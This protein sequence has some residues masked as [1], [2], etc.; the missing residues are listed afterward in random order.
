MHKTADGSVMP[1]DL[2][3]RTNN[4]PDTQAIRTG[5]D[6]RS[7]PE[8]A[9]DSGFQ[10]KPEGIALPK[11]GGAIR[12]IGEKFG[13]NPVT[14]TGSMSVPIAT[15]PGRSGFSPQLSLN[16][17]SGAGNGPF[18]F[19]W[20]LGLPQITRKTDKGLPQYHDAQES[21]VYILSGTEDLVPVTID[22][23][24]TWV[25]ER[26][27]D[28]A[29]GSDTYMVQRYRPR[30]EGLFARIERW[31]RQGDGDVHWRSI[32]RDNVLTLY[33]TDANSR[34]ADAADPLRV[35]TW[36][37]SETRDDKG[38]A[39]V[40]DYKAEDGTGVD[41][42]RA[43]ERNR[44][45][46]DDPRR[47]TNRHL[48]RIRYGNR[49]TL[50]D[51]AGQRPARL[52]A[53]ALQGAGWMFEAVFDYGEHVAEAPTPNEAGPW[54]SRVDPFSS[55]RAGFE[56]RTARLCRRVLMFHH[57]D[58]EPGVGTDCLVR[59]TDFGYS[60]DQD[61][62]N[63][64]NPAYT[65]LLSVTQ[66]SYKRDAGAYRKRSLPPVEFAYTQPSVQDSVHELDE[67]SLANLPI[68]LDGAAYQWIDLHGEGIPGILTEQGGGWFY[69]RNVSPISD[70]QVEFA[71]V[72]RVALTPNAGL[73][74]GQAQFM[75]LAGDGQPDL[76]L[77][78]GPVPGLYEHGAEEG[79]E[80]FR[81]FT[82]YLN[83][84]TRDPNLKLVDLDGDGHADVL[85]SENDAFVWHAS[86]AE[87]GFGPARRVQHALDDEQ[88]PR[89]VFADGTESIYLADL[90]GDG[91]T[92]LVRIRNGGV[93][94]WP[95]LG[96]GRF[97]AKVTMD[98]SPR[99]DHP[100]QFD[101]SRIR[102]ADV[103]GSGTTDIIYLHRD[104]VRLYFNQSGNSWSAAQQ[105]NVFPR[106]DDFAS[107]V[108]I[109]LFGNGTACLVWSSPLPGDARRSMRYV[110]LMGG[111]KP[112]LLVKS[113]NNLGAETIVT[114]APSTKF[115]LA[116]KA[117]GRPWITKLPF[118][119]HCVENVTVADKW[120]Q[121][122]FSTSYSYHHGFF[123][124]VER[125]FRGFGR[126]E[127][128]DVESYGEFSQGNS[129]SPYITDDKTLYQPPVKTI[130]W[131]HTGAAS[132]RERVLSQFAHEYFPGGFESAQSGGLAVL[133]DFQE[134][135]LPEPDLRVED[136]SAD[137]W[138]ETLRACRG[139]TLRQETYELDVDAL[140][141]GEHQPVKLF[142]TAY[143]NCHIRR[144][145]AKAAN[146][147]AVF[148][149]AESEAITYHYELD[150][151]ADALRPD[152][153]IEHTLHLQ[154]DEYANILQ[155]VT[156]VYPRLGQ[157]EDEA[158][159]PETVALIR[160][161]QR[162]R[163]VA[164]AETRYTNDVVEPDTYRLR[165]P[166]EALTYELTGISPEDA[167]DQ[168]T[169]N[170]RDNRYFTLD[171]LRG[172]RLSEVHQT[173]GVAVPEIAYHELANGSTPQKRLVEH[174]RTLF[175]KDDGALVDAP[176]PLGQL[177]R[178]GLPF[179]RYT[180]ALTRDLLDAVFADKLTPDALN[181][182]GDASVSGY[183]S[184]A[185]LAMRFAG[186]G[187][188]GQ[189][190]VRSGIAG[191]APDAAQHFYLPERFTDPFGNVTT[192]EYDP[193]DLF[194]A[195][196][197]DAL[198][199][200]TRVERFDFRVLSPSEIR[201][202]N[203]NLSEVFFD[204]LGLPSAMAVQGKGAEGDTLA[205][206]TDV[207]A[208]PDTSD[209]ETFFGQSDLDDTQA[210]AWLA[211][212][213]A[214]HI[215]YFG[216]TLNADGTIAWGAHPAC[217]CGI[218][219]ETHVS[220][221]APGEQSAL[222]TSFEYSDGM[223]SVLVKKTQAEPEA[224][225]QPLR[226]IAN[227]KTI[228]NNK[229][230]AVKQYEP[231]FS[232]LGHR[233]EEPLEVGVTA[234]TYYDAVGR[235]VRSE[236]PDGTFSRV[237]FSPWLTRSFDANDTVRESTWYSDRNPPDPA[238]PLPRDI[239]GRLLVTQDQRAAW[240]AAQHAGTPSLTLV[241]SL[242]RA[243]IVVAHN[244]VKDAAGSHVFGAETW[245]DDYQV[246]FTK[247]DAEGKP[248]W[249]RDARRNLVM[250]YITPPVP[251]DQSDDPVS[252]FAPCYDIAGNL[253]FQH[254][255]DAGERW[256]LNDAAGGLLLAW[257]GRG[258][259]FRTEYDP[260]RR[261]IA[262]FGSGIDPQDPGREIQF[263]HVIYGDTPNNGLSDAERQALNVRGKRLRHRDTAGIVVSV[264]LNPDTGEDEAFDFKGNLLRHT[265]QLIQNYTSTSDWSQP[266]ALEPELFTSS[267]RFDALNRPIQ[268]VVPH[269]DRPGTRLTVIRPG[270]NE[271]GLLG[272]VDVWLEQDTEPA[273][274]LGVQ[275]ATQHVVTDVDYDAKGQRSRIRYGNGVGTTYER[276]PLT[277]RLIHLLT[278]R[279][280]GFAD[281]WP[282][283]PD[284]PR[285]GIQ[286]LTYFYDPVGNITHIRDEAQHTIFFSG[287]R[288]EPSA[289][290]EYDAIYRLI[291][292]SGREHVGQHASP[293]VTDDDSP[294]M[295]QPLPT[296][297]AALRNYTER[298]DYDAVGNILRMIH[299]AGANGSWTR[300]YD[301][302]ATSN[303]LLATSLPGDAIDHFS[304]RY[305]YD[306]HGSMTRM[307][308][309]PLM[310]WDF[311]DRLQATAKQV[312]TTGSPET[313]W[314][315]YDGSGQ[316]VR[317]VT[318]RPA[319][320]GQTPT[321][322][323]E[324][325]YLDTFE[326]YRE[327]E[328]DGVTVAL[329][330]ETLNVMDDQQRVALVETK[331][332]DTTA[333]FTSSAPL[334]RYQFSNHLGSASLELNGE[335]QIISYEEYHPYG[336][337]SYQGGRSAAEVGL[338]RYRYIG[339]ERDEESGLG[340]HAARYYASWLGRW[341]SCDP[342][343]LR[344]GANVY[345]YV[346]NS[347][348]RLIDPEGTE[349][350]NASHEVVKQLVD[351]V[352][353][354][355]NRMLDV[356]E[357]SL[358]KPNVHWRDP[359]KIG[360]LAGDLIREDLEKILGKGNFEVT[361]RG[362]IID[363][364]LKEVP[365]DI[366]L[367][368]TEASKRI[369]QSIGLERNARENSR[370]LFYVMGDIPAE[371]DQEGR[372]TKPGKITPPDPHDFT[373][374]PFTKQQLSRLETMKSG[375]RAKISALAGKGAPRRGADDGTA[376]SRLGNMVKSAVVSTATT[377][378]ISL[379]TKAQLPSVAEVA[380][381]LHPAVSLA[382]ARNHDETVMPIIL[383][384]V[385]WKVV[386][387]AGVGYLMIK[388]GTY[389][390]EVIERI[391][392]KYPDDPYGRKA[393]AMI[394]MTVGYGTAADRQ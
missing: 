278:D 142:S 375:I 321:R 104:G 253:L 314:Y 192:V 388:G 164:Y 327:Y 66:S 107:I 203:A 41:L 292:A 177:G 324:R 6:P 389:R 35:F 286:N 329:E 360:K 277:F 374:K 44:G 24:G 197:T 310:R 320:P 263:D 25:R 220:Q 67:E 323:K 99:F 262:S 230:K 63:A 226:W 93:C 239:T 315:V 212:A 173:E 191:F 127:Q 46:R 325:V 26:L 29:I 57:F 243:V 45:E 311:H 91:L 2:Q 51:S 357:D 125:E 88:G 363:I 294:R 289:D 185:T 238:L 371:V 386:V 301:Y 224:P 236:M 19:G 13:A 110:D 86:L 229:D 340:Y 165:A 379:V 391:R 290:Y 158:L 133:G 345:A 285:G 117:A 336:S 373:T 291:T 259:A 393:D 338:K 237:E 59:S 308:H 274:L 322:M 251:D 105:L 387:G 196:T 261:S 287:Q 135:V 390:G 302:D 205:G 73:T 20:A 111:Q 163:H 317:K 331:T 79:W 380:E 241:D 31:T 227:G 350:K 257:D 376:P 149:V 332:L 304:G 358:K 162:E 207:L 249:I 138:R 8:S 296:D 307:P 218:A 101:H 62:A 160:S 54:R 188:D 195:S 299:Q 343:G 64:R 55:Y 213:S 372:V 124:G 351:E 367:K 152:P 276:D 155:S 147:H 52:S 28:R 134:N 211:D 348:L 246:T 353:T 154:H 242:G 247:L 264:G 352:K 365:L 392:A 217:A 84:D 341:T 394:R 186:G 38:N 159:P 252:G 369:K 234:L 14:G 89:L 83:R 139:M 47:K 228:L 95:N 326:V 245:R 122:R 72:E 15:S 169:P 182:L 123:D 106:V 349:S 109:D 342:A 12:G 82:A 68:G 275:S 136:S 120:R 366:E 132:E 385:G 94:F 151:R 174:E 23:N 303:R 81:P 283:P 334:I 85:V 176:L 273:G 223:G 148:L 254:S 225:S 34:I 102:L 200:T 56:V 179:E 222:Q 22:Q 131:Y 121:T 362:A 167:D 244:R 30:I 181:R 115:Y 171:E 219:R 114:Y 381:G 206:L 194:M 216:E 316:R 300:R 269:S 183:L 7:N 288:V 69:K 5:S 39:V 306:P 297:A 11:G 103:D 255:M 58:G 210:R 161:V 184:G 43:H 48:K 150:L 49:N 295:R 271:G 309:L 37:I 189:Y 9:G 208:N 87:Q 172:L 204:V 383:M 98:E 170:A 90:D 268:L 118:P 75:D 76:V 364:S 60:H 313:T 77:L 232:P 202:I 21:D 156:V 100:D 92:D 370:L 65:F 312:V 339:M 359:M 298:Y 16:Y 281:D 157:F 384:V 53:T 113:L 335:G 187:T 17:D 96:Y 108:P 33:G 330:R 337:T 260:M 382:K 333:P 146:R 126:V 265:R 80:H 27:S 377:A 233:F 61:P 97:G 143:H 112:H 70:R 180:L 32:S 250:Q 356:A 141:R 215:Y 4:H 266:P 354:Y 272:R 50:L 248:L 116:D 346:K 78:D 190:W 36:L 1:G 145:Q 198:G 129:A 40:Y 305:E 240:L 318:E 209:L 221:L 175:F 270:Y 231:Y 361:V 256:T 201:D 10:V 168:L 178:L 214:R 199:N 284:P 258:H 74:N 3:Q 328:N 119:V 280:A 368:K 128:V 319:A 378:I 18:G 130:T 282:Q 355:Y 347:P 144:V 153:R 235:A 193:L 71:P 293:Q 166:C 267:I 279:G 344:D 42:G 140:E 137:E